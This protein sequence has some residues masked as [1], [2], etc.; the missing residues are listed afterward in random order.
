MTDDRA[1]EL[2]SWYALSAPEKK[3][4]GLPDERAVAEFLGVSTAFV[5]KAKEDKRVR[6]RVKERLDIELLY[7]VVELRPHLRAAASDPEH[8][9][10]LKAVRVVEELAGNLKAKGMGNVPV[11]VNVMNALGFEAMDDEEI[12]LKARQILGQNPIDEAQPRDDGDD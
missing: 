11:N 8:R 2:A 9:D 5:R 4:S 12:V 10:F 6:D 7:T 3:E 1:M